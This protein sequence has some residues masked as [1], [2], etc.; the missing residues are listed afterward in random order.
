MTVKLGILGVSSGNGHPYSWSAICNGYDALAMESC[1]Y[2][3]IPE[4]LAKQKWP[5]DQLKGVHI[6]HV[7]ADD[8]DEA[9]KIS[10]ATYIENTV[11]RPEDML[12]HIDGLLL[13][14]DDAQN[15]LYLAKPFLEA[16]L[17]VYIDKPVALS[18]RDFDDLHTLQKRPN[19]IFTCSAL[20]YAKEMLLT[21]EQRQKLGDISYIEGTVPKYWETY[22]MHII[23]PITT[24][25]GAEKAPKRLFT[26][27]FLDNG[28]FLSYRYDNGPEVHLRAV[29]DKINL[30]ISLRI[31][32]TLSETTLVFEDSFRAFKAALDAFT[33]GVRNNS[34]SSCSQFNR[35]TVEI[36][37]MGMK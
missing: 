29:G 24:I 1:G 10:N 8:L 22:A 26:G 2:P 37:E 36:V 18:L 32:G 23:D 4:Y 5:H 30:P 17:P 9:K 13:A 3:T 21:N 7:W 19:Q 20:R 11:T 6:T 15:H 25:V 14:R 35:R 31:I 12:E 34:N 27:P 33:T 16:G 28:R